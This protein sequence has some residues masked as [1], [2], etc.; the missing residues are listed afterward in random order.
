MAGVIERIVN[1]MRLPAGP[2]GS[3][4]QWSTGGGASDTT[5][6]ITAARSNSAVY[7]V[8]DAIATAFPEPPLMVVNEDADGDESEVVGHELVSL[9]RN[10]NPALDEFTN[11][12]ITQIY[13]QTSG[14]AYWLK[15]RNRAGKPVQLWP[16][17]DAYI[18]PEWDKD[19]TD[20]ITSY[21]YE[22]VPGKVYNIEPRDVVHFRFGVDSDNER[23][24][25]AP[26]WYVLA[27][28]FGDNEATRYTASILKNWGIP[29]IVIETDKTPLPSEIARIS[30][31]F[32]ARYSGRNRGRIGFLTG[33]MKANVIGASP[34]AL[35][36]DFAHRVPEERISGVY[37]VPAIVAGLGAGLERAT[38]ANFREAREMFTER[39]MTSLWRMAA[40]QLETQLLPD[41]DDS[42]KQRVRFN[43]A[44]V[45]A[46]QEDEDAKWA[47]AQAALTA[48]GITR[49]EF[50]RQ[51]GLVPEPSGTDDVYLMPLSVFEVPAGTPAP[52]PE[53]AAPKAMIAGAQK[54]AR[55][56]SAASVHRALVRSMARA[57]APAEAAVNRAFAS[58][59]D[60][61]VSG[62]KEAA[63]GDVWP[64]KVTQL[65]QDG[66]RAVYVGQASQV[67]E[68]VSSALGV[69]G[70]FNVSHPMVARYLEQSSQRVVMIS[71]TTREA[72]QAVLA[73]NVD[74][75]RDELRR[76]IRQTVEETYRGRSAAIARTELRAATNQTSAARYAD[77]GITMVD[78][79][80]GDGDEV[81]ASR[82]GQRV[83]LEQFLE[84][85]A[86][87]HPNGTIS[88]MPVLE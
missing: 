40:A 2:G 51:V 25:R 18:K 12:Y 82:D 35:N 61:A 21:R 63:I 56:A 36:I 81:C 11:W 60:L 62:L 66:I 31:E 38:Y 13:L 50:L 20:W 6:S 58:A 70:V 87:E 75:P 53:A 41:F 24:G 47:R 27:E 14:N 68:L 9:V 86:S 7:M 78:V 28:V 72:L 15:F 42:G 34:A 43:L 49:A 4:L 33:G 48:G 46:L 1:G 54:A 52:A 80:D 39:K 74:A 5:V 84:W 77:A 83:T 8:V 23:L 59:A 55:G 37:G 85:E 76:L 65:L 64:E 17:S 67:W 32:A 71:E 22:P 30:E 29:P 26:L 57:Q 44:T 79:V 10:P 88:A 69:S 73:E 16:I 3:G 45:R 19:G